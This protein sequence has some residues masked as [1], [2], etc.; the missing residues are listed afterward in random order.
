LDTLLLVLAASPPHKD[1]GSISSAYHRHSMAAM[2]TMSFPRICVSA[3]E[4]ENQDKRYTFETVDTLRRTYGDEAAI[5]FIIGSDSFDELHKWKEPGRIL[6]NC[7][8]VVAARPGYEIA[9][10]TLASKA[11]TASQIDDVRGASA[12][13]PLGAG[14]GRSRVYLTDLAWVDVS[15]SDIR[16]RVGEGLSIEG[17][18]PG[19]VID[20]IG[21]YGLYKEPGGS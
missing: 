6:D 8:I 5:F 9:S 7:S 4:L 16:R 3:I 13:R 1:P 10:E 20:Y 17:L 12:R 18:T 21:K 15:S 14:P 19:A 11:L 2:A